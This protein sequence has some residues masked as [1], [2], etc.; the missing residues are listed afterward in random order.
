MDVID[1]RGRHYVAN[2]DLGCRG[3]RSDQ[4]DQQAIISADILNGAPDWL[5]V[6]A[7]PMRERSSGVGKPTIIATNTIAQF[8]MPHDRRVF[9]VER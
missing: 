1:T 2:Q 3:L 9:G 4:V 7:K 8:P 6:G 5:E